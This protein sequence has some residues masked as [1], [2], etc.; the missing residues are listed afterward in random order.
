MAFVIGGKEYELTNDEWMFPAKT[1]SSASLAQG[2][3]QKLTFMSPG[4][5]GPQIMAQLDTDTWDAPPQEDDF[6]YVQ[7]EADIRSSNGAKSIKA[8]SS[9]I[10]TMDISHKMFLVGDVFMRKFYTIF[11]RDENKVGL[12]KAKGYSGHVMA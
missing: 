8:C 6:D 3:L 11:D 10:M 7:A 4:P 2:G 5:L 12:A 1:L 9:T